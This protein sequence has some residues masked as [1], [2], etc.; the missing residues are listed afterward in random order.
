MSHE[1]AN[2]PPKIP[3]TPKSQPESKS[4]SGCLMGMGCLLIGSLFFNFI[5]LVMVGQLGSKAAGSRSLMEQKVSGKGTSKIA[6]IR[7][8]GTIT[9]HRTSIRDT[10]AAN[11]LIR[12]LKRARR[13]RLVKGLLLEVNSPGGSVTA[14]D[15]IY[16]EMVKFRKSGKPIVVLMGDTC[17]SGC[18]Y[19]SAPANKIYA[20]PTSVT[21]SIGVIISTLNFYKFLESH[22]I[23]GVTIA[24]KENKALLSPFHPV[25]EEHRKILK[26]IVDEMFQRFV[27][28][29]SKWRKIPKEQVL[30]FA[31]GRIFSAK[32]A[33]EYKLIDGIGYEKEAKKA[34]LKLAKLSTAKFVR[35]RQQ[36]DLM[37][38]FRSYAKLP[39]YVRDSRRVSIKELLSAKAPKA[40][41]IWNDAVGQ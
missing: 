20:H 37:D 12:Q 40:Y 34:I 39:E 15:Q 11:I 31:D 27:G 28:I 25:K 6:V 17:A 4:K 33:K 23:Q 9:S 8:N 32:K 19:M 24:S 14:S 26:N 41:Y 29:V 30:E 22:G 36:I 2:F 21:G 35:Y 13:D 38:I 7:M 18:V 10:A 16:H 3:F 1:Q 5:L